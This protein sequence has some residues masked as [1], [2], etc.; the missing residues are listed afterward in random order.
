[1]A[2]FSSVAGSA[3]AQKQLVADMRARAEGRMWPRR[4]I[5]KLV[6]WGG[7]SM[8]VLLL[9]L[10]C[11]VV[12]LVGAGLLYGIEHTKEKDRVDEYFRLLTEMGGP[13]RPSYVTDEILARGWPSKPNGGGLATLIQQRENFG[14]CQ[15]PQQGSYTWSFAGSCYYMLTTITTI[16]YGSFVPDSDGGRLATMLFGLIGLLAYGLA[17]AK[18]TQLLNKCLSST[19]ASAAAAEGANSATARR[20]R[21]RPTS[22]PMQS[23]GACCV[24][25]R[26]SWW[27]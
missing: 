20:P 16:G 8:Q 21:L 12:L 6:R 2:G 4:M 15:L 18:L 25:S 26:P 10:L 22:S 19:S 13:T 23:C 17:N 11:A 7:L 9:W 24:R 3:V 1:M 5:D 27:W 14:L